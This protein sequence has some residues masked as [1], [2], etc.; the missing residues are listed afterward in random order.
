MCWCWVEVLDPIDDVIGH[1]STGRFGVV[2][3]DEPH[4]DGDG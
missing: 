2:A 1:V 3:N 4:I